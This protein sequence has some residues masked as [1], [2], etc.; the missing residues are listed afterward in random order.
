MKALR[1][2]DTRFDGLPDYP[3]PARYLEVPAGD[4][5]ALRLHYVDEG[6]RGAAPVLML[7]G[8][9]S[10][11]FLYRFVIA[12]V[13]SAGLRAVAP[14]LIGF[15]RSDKP[16]LRS[17]YTF[18]RHVDWVR[19]FVE[20]LDLRDITLL[21]QDWGGLIGLRLVAEH[22]ERFA[23]VIAANTG[24]PTGDEP[25]TAALLEW[26]RQSQTLPR[27]PTGK[28]IANSCKRPLAPE[29]IAAYDA[30]FPDESY[31]AGARHFPMLI[32]MT[33][34]DPAAPA[35]RRAWESLQRFER[36]FL[37]VAGDGDPYTAGFEQKMQ[38]LI[39]GAAGQH[40]VVLRGVGHFLQEDAG[41]ELGQITIRFATD[42]GSVS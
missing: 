40:H 19:S 20:Q 5:S 18:Q 38:R 14:D 1:T 8:E 12:A 4:D 16:A 33:P 34:D 27:F 31:Q 28:I 11:S 35:C 39:P 13:R 24:L 2:P 15:G 36:P 6:P 10:W 22:P 3:Y 37:T 26:Q 32:P 9:P 29:V 21:C 17:D 42:A 7:H 41:A 30:P 25:P 23:R